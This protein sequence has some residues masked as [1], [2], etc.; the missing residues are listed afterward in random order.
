MKNRIYFFSFIVLFFTAQAA[1]SQVIAKGDIAFTGY[2]SAYNGT[3]TP[4]N[5]FSFIVLRPG[6]LV[7]GTVINFTDN[8]WNSVTNAFGG[9]GEGIITWTSPALAQLTEV[10]LK[11]V[12]A[13]TS[14]EITSAGSATV[15]GAFQLSIAGDQVLAYQGTFAAPTFITGIHANSEITS[16]ANQPSDNANWDRIA[17]GGWT[18]TQSRSS[19]PPGLTGGTDAAMI[20]VNPGTSG[21]EKDNGKFNCSYGATASAALLRTALCD[22]AKWLLQ[23]INVYT[24]P[25][26]CS[27]SITTVVPVHLVS[28]SGQLINK[29]TL[30]QWKAENEINAASYAVEKSTDGISYTEIGSVAAFN[31]TATNSYSFKDNHISETGKTL[32]YRLKQNDIDGHFTYSD[33]IR[34]SQNLKPEKPFLFPVPAADKTTLQIEL[35]EAA[36]ADLSIV[37]KAGL[38]IKTWRQPLSKGINLIPVNTAS[39]VSG[40]YFIRVR[41]GSISE[42]LKMIKL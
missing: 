28:F 36:T 12:S 22:P 37:N 9:S 16:G 38:Q 14:M 2:N 4:A 24:L 25:T 3:G 40:E 20:V 29:Q 6:G 31:T 18:Y 15:S 21:A 34:L 7:A 33:V 10:T 13:G 41:A 26:A 5:Y 8:G 17:T 30:L 42:S 19:I 27:Y 39:L 32:F 23:D 1:T 35:A 11:V